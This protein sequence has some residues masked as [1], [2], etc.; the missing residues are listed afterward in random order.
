MKR[1]LF[2]DDEPNVL[3]GLRRMLHCM[4]GDWDL[5]FATSGAEALE[6]LDDAPFDIVVS[7]MRMPG[8]SG[9]ELLTLVRERHPRVVRIILS[10]QSDHEQ[11]MRT[12]GPAHRYLS[13]P[14]SPEA[15][16]EALSRAA[17]LSQVIT[18]DFLR[19][20]ASSTDTL[21]SIPR[22]YT[23]LEELLERPDAS[24]RDVAEVVAADQAMTAKILQLVNSAYF[25]LPRK[26]GSAE[27]AISFLGLN[28]VRALVLSAHVFAQL[29]GDFSERVRPDRL[30]SHS[31]HIA[32]AA[33]AIARAEGRPRAEQQEALTAGLLHDVGVLVLAKHFQDG[34]DELLACASERSIPICAAE[35]EA[36]GATHADVGGFLLGLW[37]LPEPLVDAVGRHHDPSPNGGREFSALVAVQAAEALCPDS[38]ACGNMREHGDLDGSCA[39]DLELAERVSHWRKV[40]C[41]LWAEGGQT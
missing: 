8:M 7:D 13:K 1:I 5:R 22:L 18:S 12:I 37:G 10:G 40:V 29:D 11:I 17:T 23:Q 20:L 3:A 15:L 19:D 28:V 38:W 4:R 35:K 25:G 30:W 34:Y 9:A 36:L 32:R 39:V 24:I 14:C 6:E 41:G 16:R 27:Q 26:I 31:V 2:V 33:E 21:P